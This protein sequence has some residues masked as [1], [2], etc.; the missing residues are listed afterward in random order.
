MPRLGIICLLAGL[1]M[2]AT[3]ASSR[4]TATA[5]CQGGITKSGTRA[6]TGIVAADPAVLPIGTVLR[7]V[8]GTATG[9]YTVMDTGRAVRGRKIDIFIPNCGR[10]TRFGSQKLLVR[11]LR[12]GWDPKATTSGT[13]G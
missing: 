6:R 10:A 13:Q 8:S 7:I 11:V 5:Y 2:A 12:R 4:M 1:S 3:P 9:I